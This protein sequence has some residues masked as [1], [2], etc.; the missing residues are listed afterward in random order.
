[1][2]FITFV[3]LFATVFAIEC[4]ETQYIMNDQCLECDLHCS[5]KCEDNYGCRTCSEGY[6]TLNGQCKTCDKNC[7][8]CTNEEGCISCKKGY[9]VENK[10]CSKKILDGF[11]IFM[12]V[13]GSLMTLIVLICFCIMFVEWIM[14]IIK[15]KKTNSGYKPLQ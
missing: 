7:E 10:I 9:Y 4:N 3:L 6:Y 14:K 11:D 8:E 12:I 1:M 5:E 15:N 2:K 13:I